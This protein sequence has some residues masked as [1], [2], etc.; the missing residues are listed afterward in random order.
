MVIIIFFFLWDLSELKEVVSF[1]QGVKWKDVK[2][3]ERQPSSQLPSC[4]PMEIGCVVMSDHY[5]SKYTY[6]F[7]K[8]ESLYVAKFLLGE[9]DRQQ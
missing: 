3:K 7:T 5:C 6:I 4:Y 9:K 1:R 2:C 8:L